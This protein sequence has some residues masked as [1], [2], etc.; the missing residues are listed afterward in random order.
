M[1]FRKPSNTWG[2]WLSSI[3]ILGKI[4]AALGFTRCRT[5][6]S[7][8]A[9]ISPDTK[10]YFMSLDMPIMEAFGMSESGGAHTLTDYNK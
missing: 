9:P 4:R 5:L 3:L 2:Y 8:A 1:F 7:A 6:V 10:S